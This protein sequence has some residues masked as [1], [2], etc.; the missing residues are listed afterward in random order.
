VKIGIKL[1]VIC[2]ALDLS[3]PYGSTPA[4]WQLFKAMY[5]LGHELIIIPYN[6]HDISSLWWRSYPNPNY[7]KGLILE[8]LL[9]MVKHSNGKKNI[10]FIPTLARFLAKPNIEKLVN[11]ILL[12]EKDVEAVLMINLPL[13]QLKGF[14]TQ[15]RRNHANISVILYDIDVP[16]S[17][18]SYGGFTFNHYVGAD[19][20]E[21]DS[22]IIPSEGSV[23]ELMDLGATDVHIVHFGVD[24]D[25]Y[26]PMPVKQDIDVLFFG[27][28]SRDRENN[29]RMMITDP[30]KLLKYKFVI[31]GRFL[32]TDVGNAVT[33]K[34][35]S[36]TEWR[37][38]C[39]GSKINLNVVRETHAKVYGTS[40]SRPFEL[41]SMKCCI[42]SAPYRGLENWFVLG[43]EVLIA[44]SSKECIELYQM[45]IDD[46]DLRIKIGEA[47]R[48]RVK[49][50]HTS[51]HR[52]EQIINIIR[53]I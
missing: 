11:R 23:H 26:T 51:R 20:S 44:S 4:L 33:T 43:K 29:I 15:L 16:T 13:N 17:L 32:H 37:R 38:H 50:E 3:K 8:K 40:T 10:P 36:F 46:D 2:A 31:S 5:E 22:F 14:A 52:A 35:F 6:G 41:A 21:Y 25:L 47:A 45:L 49:K 7:Y 28:G 19:L 48:A 24:P 53:K 39:S 18:P 34:P 42:V 30:S 9:K 1:L 27:N 12:N